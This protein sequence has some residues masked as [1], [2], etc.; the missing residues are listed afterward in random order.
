[1]KILVILG[2]FRSSRNTLSYQKSSTQAKGS[3]SHYWWSQ[4]SWCPIDSTHTSQP[5]T[6]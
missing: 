6:T 2:A 3:K 5:E 4:N 1:M